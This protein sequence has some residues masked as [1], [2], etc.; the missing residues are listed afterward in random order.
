MG[1]DDNNA[2]Q[3]RRPCPLCCM[4]SVEASDRTRLAIHMLRECPNRLSAG[5]A[6]GVRRAN[7][8]QLAERLAG[9]RN[10]GFFHPM[11]IGTLSVQRLYWGLLEHGAVG[12]DADDDATDGVTLDG[13]LQSLFARGVLTRPESRSGDDPPT[14]APVEDVFVAVVRAVMDAVIEP[15]TQEIDPAVLLAFRLPPPGT[16]DGDSTAA[17]DG[18]DDAGGRGG[19]GA[20]D[21]DAIELFERILRA[22]VND[23]MT[24]PPAAVTG[25][26]GAAAAEAPEDPTDALR[27]AVHPIVSLAR[28]L[29]RAA[30]LPDNLGPPDGS[31][32]REFATQ[33][34]RKALVDAALAGDAEAA[35]DALR[36]AVLRSDGA[37]ADD[38]ATVVA[39]RAA[40]LA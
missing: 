7:N 23:D 19:S 30:G 25:A 20:D 24:T 11:R 26:A 14:L 17:A 34:R 3:W 2:G 16:G 1:D 9:L 21:V 33:Q 15:S 10:D 31:P 36:L 39:V 32:A 6:H 27:A 38:P 40:A 12:G 18:A 28:R 37:G 4:F 5:S 29:R 22:T 13:F 8:A 35:A